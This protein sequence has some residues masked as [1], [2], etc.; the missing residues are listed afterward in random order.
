MTLEDKRVVVLGGASGIGLAV[1]EAAMTEGSDV[2]VVSRQQSRFHAASKL[3]G[4]EAEGY[5]AN[6]SECLLCGSIRS[7]LLLSQSEG[8]L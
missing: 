2:A 8:L 7:T 6:L 3:F 1:A 5:V 4:E